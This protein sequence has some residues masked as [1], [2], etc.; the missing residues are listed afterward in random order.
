MKNGRSTEVKA[1]AG[2]DAG[3][4]ARTPD[5]F[6][7][8]PVPLGT[9]PSLDALEGRFLARLLRGDECTAADWL[10]D[11]RSMRLAAEVHELRDL[12]WAVESRRETVRTADRGRLAHVA[13]YWL[14]PHQRDAAAAS[15]RGRRFLAAVDAAEGRRADR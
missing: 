5:L 13:R 6:D 14:E 4:V 1:T 15:E 3:I 10:D 8:A 11:A 7:D 2:R 12:G 9:W